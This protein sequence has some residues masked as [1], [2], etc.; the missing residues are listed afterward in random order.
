[1]A[2]GCTPPGGIAEPRILSPAAGEERILIP[3][4]PAERQEV[5]LEADSAW[6][7]DLAWFVDGE[8]LGTVSAEKRLWW[9]PRTGRH[10]VVVRDERGRTASV[11]FSVS[12]RRMMTGG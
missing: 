6:T 11:R 9:T 10:E 5:A 7:G 3:G 4:L 8:W 12:T 1:M 2:E